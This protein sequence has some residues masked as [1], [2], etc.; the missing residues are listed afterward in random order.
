MHK[1]HF[2]E[3]LKYPWKKPEKLLNILWILIPI[4]GFF[5]IMGYL[6]KIVIELS[7][8]KK[9]GLPK[10]GKFVDNL[11]V[12]FM[13]FV[14]MIPTFI[15]LFIIQST[16]FIG[17]ILYL[18][19]VLLALPWLVINLFV[20]GEFKALWELKEVYEVVTKRFTEYLIALLKT[21][22]FGIIYGLA[23]IVLIGIPC[24]MFGG[25]YYLID[26]YRKK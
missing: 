15:V 7:K 11:G 8:G 14:Y 19:I 1:E 26:F 2:I 18:L 5:A 12:G 20:K 23:S 13:L 25:Y 4:V 3:G 10:F 6:K 17:P 9:E 16:P 21:I 24:Y 22:V